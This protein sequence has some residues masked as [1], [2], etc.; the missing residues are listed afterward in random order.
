M[1]RLRLAQI[2]KPY[3][4]LSF[5]VVC[6]HIG[7]TGNCR[8]VVFVI[9]LYAVGTVVADFRIEKAFLFEFESIQSI[10]SV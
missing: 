9:D 2:K 10:A 7:N 4:F 1:H 3:K 6:E 5:L 8:A